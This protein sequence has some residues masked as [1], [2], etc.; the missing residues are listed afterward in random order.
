M[1]IEALL[2]TNAWAW[3]L[4]VF[5]LLGYHLVTYGLSLVNAN[6]G[7]FPVFLIYVLLL[8]VPLSPN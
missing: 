6:V 3:C 5:P 8:V 1:K 2:P 4:L 7:S